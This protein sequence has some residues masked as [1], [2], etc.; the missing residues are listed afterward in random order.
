MIVNDKRIDFKGTIK[1][2]V[3]KLGFPKDKIAIL[4]NG[5]MVKRENWESFL[6]KEN[7][8]VEIVSLVGGG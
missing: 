1:E 3:E 7:D 2:L 8:Y 5:E 6:L 4:V